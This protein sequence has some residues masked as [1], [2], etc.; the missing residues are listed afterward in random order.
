[1]SQL[2]NTHLNKK[3][4]IRARINITCFPI[5]SLVVTFA[6]NPNANYLKYGESWYGKTTNQ[7][8]IDGHKD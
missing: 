3:D 7:E 8:T 5:K 1:M 4:D 6:S 2:K